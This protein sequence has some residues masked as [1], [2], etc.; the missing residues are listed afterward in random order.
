MW[1]GKA[2]R[3]NFL[4]CKFGAAAYSL[5]TVPYLNPESCL[6]RLV[7]L[8]AGGGPTNIHAVTSPFWVQEIVTVPLEMDPCVVIKVPS[9]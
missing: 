3:A 6:G 9:P 5:L 2:R 1:N 4:L 7:D 8:L